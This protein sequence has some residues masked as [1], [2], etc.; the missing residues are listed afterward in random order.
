MASTDYDKSCASIYNVK[1]KFYTNFKILKYVVEI[2]V[3][4]F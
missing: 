2:N 1:I 4:Q 3:L